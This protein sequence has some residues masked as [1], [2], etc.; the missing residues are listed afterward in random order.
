MLT[1]LFC[2]IILIPEL[3]LSPEITQTRMAVKM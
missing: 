1:D 2:G 3:H